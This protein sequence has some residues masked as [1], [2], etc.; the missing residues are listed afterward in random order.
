MACCI[1]QKGGTECREEAHSRLISVQRRKRNLSGARQNIHHHILKWSG[2]RSFS[3]LLPGCRT[4]RLRNACPCPF[5]LSVGG[6]GV[7]FMNAWLVWMNGQG[8]GD[9]AFFPPQIVMEVKALVCELPEQLGLPFSRLSHRDI[10]AEAVRCGITASISG[11][12]VW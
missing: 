5:R 4:S 7:S 9:L 2:P 6:A 11:A 3:L 1:S 12:T 8:E 10:A